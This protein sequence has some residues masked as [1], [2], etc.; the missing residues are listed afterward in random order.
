[1]KRPVVF[2]EVTGPDSQPRYF[3]TN[4]EG[5]Y[6]N[7]EEWRA[8]RREGYLY[9]DGQEASKLVLRLQRKNYK[10][11]K[12]RKRYVVPIELEVLSD[13]P[14][15]FEI[16]RIWVQRAIVTNIAYGT[17]GNGPINNSIVIAQMN[18]AKMK[19]DKDESA[20]DRKD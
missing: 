4:S 10:S 20:T 14:V 15:A 18:Y 2:L 8:N 11:C 5:Q 1:M 13:D 12:H 17:V 6:W 19:E 7:G 3:I 9:L 16:L